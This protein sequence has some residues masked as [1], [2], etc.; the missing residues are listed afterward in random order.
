MSDHE[1]SGR[2]PPD[3]RP[4][5]EIRATEWFWGQMD[6]LASQIESDMPLDEPGAE[7]RIRN[8]IEQIRRTA[9]Y[10]RARDMNALRGLIGEGEDRFAYMRPLKIAFEKL[11]LKERKP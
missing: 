1:P 8:Q 6:I 11:D 10:I 2:P 4:P 3:R 7:D 9:Q 5:A